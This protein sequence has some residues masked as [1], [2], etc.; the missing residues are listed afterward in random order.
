MS[1]AVA[2]RI[3]IAY[4]N[5]ADKRPELGAID[6]RLIEHHRRRWDLIA[7]TEAPVSLTTD[8]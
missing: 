2:A 1:S 3:E 8:N 5:L 6:A 7:P 4:F